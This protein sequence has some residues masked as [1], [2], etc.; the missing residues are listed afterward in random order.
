[1]S[2]P[3]S[4][5]GRRGECHGSEVVPLP[6]PLLLSPSTSAR[7]FLEQN[8]K[9]SFRGAAV[10]GS[11]HCAGS[12]ERRGRRAGVA[13]W[14]LSAWAAPSVT[15]GHNIFILNPNSG[16]SFMAP[17]PARGRSPPPRHGGSPEL[18]VTRTVWAWGCSC[19]SGWAVGH[20]LFLTSGGSVRKNDRTAWCAIFESERLSKLVREWKLLSHVW[21]SATPSTI[22]AVEYSRPE[23]W[24]GWPFPSP[25]DLPNPGIEPRSPALQ[26]DSLP[27][28]PPRKIKLRAS[29]KHCFFVTKHDPGSFRINLPIILFEGCCVPALSLLA[30]SGVRTKDTGC[31]AGQPGLLGT[32]PHIDRVT[33]WRSIY[34][35]ETQFYRL[36]NGTM[37]VMG[38]RTQLDWK[39]SKVLGLKDRWAEL[40]PG[41]PCSTF[42]WKTSCSSMGLTTQ[43]RPPPRPIPLR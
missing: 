35:P 24:S 4:G 15:W 33:L 22:Q 6:G 14:A 30:L 29:V 25:G 21:L 5:D 43:Y 36:Y 10:E 8:P 38:E 9:D 28:E 20:F 31:G 42:S 32:L 34:L 1:M 23:S 3:E 17:W 26:V 11:W 39:G 18:K 7:G 13:H 12:R 16:A 37:S 19:V 27:A 2:A 41:C 40:G